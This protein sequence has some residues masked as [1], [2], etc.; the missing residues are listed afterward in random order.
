MERR[1]QSHPPGI[2][3]CCYCDNNGSGFS[4]QWNI[5]PGASVKMGT[6]V[7]CVAK[8]HTT[9]WNQYM[10]IQDICNLLCFYSICLLSVTEGIN[11]TMFLNTY[12]RHSS[13][14]AW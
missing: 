7:E 13:E 9:R 3:D 2:G 11:N 5:R 4:L 10:F 12:I 1:G 14:V 8:L 6:L